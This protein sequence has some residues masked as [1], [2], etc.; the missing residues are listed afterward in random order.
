MAKAIFKDSSTIEVITEDGEKLHLEAYAEVKKGDQKA[1]ADL[2]AQSFEKNFSVDKSSMVY[3]VL[4][5]M[6]SKAGFSFYFVGSDRND[7]RV[8]IGLKIREL[9]EKKGIEAKHLASLADI[10]AANL[11]RIERGK[12]S[13]GFDILTKI[14]DALNVKVDLVE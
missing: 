3:W 12:Y 4:M 7:E 8:R 14:A 1:I 6:M 10:D 5:E 9:R 11:S 13:V 2:L